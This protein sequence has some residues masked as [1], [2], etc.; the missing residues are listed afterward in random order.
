[1]QQLTMVEVILIFGGLAILYTIS[2]IF[3][4]RFKRGLSGIESMS[5]LYY[6]VIV[7][8]LYLTFRLNAGLG[9]VI[10]VIGGAGVVYESII[11]KKL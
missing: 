4:F 9:M 3:R 1:M 8:G 6:G 5:S 7:V 2:A 10:M 11:G